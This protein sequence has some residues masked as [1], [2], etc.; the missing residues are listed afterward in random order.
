MFWR[1]E[2][3]QQEMQLMVRPGNERPKKIRDLIV[4]LRREERLQRPDG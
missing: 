2:A 1:S 3:S 4:S